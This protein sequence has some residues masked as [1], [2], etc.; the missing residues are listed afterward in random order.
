MTSMLK[1][2]HHAIKRYSIRTGTPIFKSATK[3][4]TELETAE[5]VT[6][7][8]ACTYFSMTRI[9]MNCAYLMWR[10]ETID[11]LLLAIIKD[12]TVI[13]VLAQNMFGPTSNLAKTSRYIY[14]NGE[15]VK[16]DGWFVRESVLLNQVNLKKVKG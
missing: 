1:L 13:T 9:D 4:S 14:E 3:L 12:R 5:R 15:I 6:L 16:M 8:Q 11:E 10:N 7:K 2:S